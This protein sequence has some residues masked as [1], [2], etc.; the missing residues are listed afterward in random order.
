MYLVNPLRF[1]AAQPPR[2]L[3]QSAAPKPP[4][5]D[6]PEKGRALMT[7]FAA[8]L[9]NYEKLDIAAGRTMVVVPARNEEGN[10][11]DTLDH[12]LKSIAGNKNVEL[13]IVVNASTDRTEQVAKE[14][15][16]QHKKEVR[17]HVLSQPVPGKTGAM[18]TVEKLFEKQA[19]EWMVQVDADTRIK[20]GDIQKLVDLA[21]SREQVAATGNPR[22]RSDDRARL[23]KGGINPCQVL[24]GNFIA[25]RTGPWLAGYRAILETY[26]QAAT[27]D[28]LLTAILRIGGFKTGTAGQAG[29]I[30][31]EIL[32][33]S[34]Y[35]DA[36]KQRTRWKTGNIQVA[37]LFGAVELAK[38]GLGPALRSPVGFLF[39][40]VAG[41]VRHPVSTV[42][43]GIG[44]AT[45]AV[46]ESMRHPVMTT[47]GA[48]SD[49]TW[50]LQ[51]AKA[52]RD[53]RRDA[54]GAAAKA[55]EEGKYSWI[56]PRSR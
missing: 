38:V 45:W 22:Y 23:W 11:T 36:Y 5:A 50:G 24:F 51:M 13:A 7:A 55:E 17:I 6:L 35:Q 3:E 12:L 41:N 33:T 40:Q 18:L 43:N 48:I 9:E 47:R 10:I 28:E 46:K 56:P 42:R 25:C 34:N 16:K 54:P 53:A 31:Q 44:R 39:D 4:Y 21:S 37:N 8:H 26:P 52:E 49:A 20:P 30:S 15:A 32:A 1:G 29:D 19:P 14:W 2:A 27:E